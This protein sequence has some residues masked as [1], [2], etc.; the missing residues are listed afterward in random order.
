[1]PVSVVKSKADEG[2]WTKA[3]AIAARE[4]KAKKW[5]L[6]MHIYQ[7][8]KE[9]EYQELVNGIVENLLEMTATGGVGV[10]PTGMAPPIDGK[11]V[12]DAAVNP[13]GDQALS[14]QT[15]AQLNPDIFLPLS[16]T[17]NSHHVIPKGD[18]TGGYDVARA[19]IIT[20]NQKKEVESGM[21]SLIL[22]AGKEQVEAEAE[23]KA[24]EHAADLAYE[25]ESSQ[26]QLAHDTKSLA[27]EKEAWRLKR[28]QLLFKEK[29]SPK[30]QKLKEEEEETPYP[31]SPPYPKV[32]KPS[33]NYDAEKYR[34][35]DDAVA[36]VMGRVDTNL[37]PMTP[38][39]EKDYKTN[40]TLK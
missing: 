31:T 18:Q 38:S 15:L 9:D 17:A 5:P 13:E 22:K 32:K 26:F 27:H 35:Y 34:D 6:I 40:K 16:K 29:H 19:T 11:K 12:A 30:K 21:I 24:K 37:D 33:W 1:M 4:G 8:M 28:E 14:L 3:K 23:A 2:K 25:K 36:D 39:S 20:Q 10:V 7:N